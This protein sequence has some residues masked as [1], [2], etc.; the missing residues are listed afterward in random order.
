MHNFFKRIDSSKL[1]RAKAKQETLQKEAEEQNSGPKRPHAQSV[2]DLLDDD[3]LEKYCSDVNSSELSEVCVEGETNEPEPKNSQKTNPD[4]SYNDDNSGCNNEFFS[5]PDSLSSK[6]EGDEFKELN[7][8]SSELTK[9][10]DKTDAVYFIAL[11][12]GV[13]EPAYC[14]YKVTK[15][16]CSIVMVSQNDSLFEFFKFIDSIFVEIIEKGYLEVQIKANDEILSLLQDVNRLPYKVKS[17]YM[18]A[19]HCIRFIESDTEQIIKDAVK[20]FI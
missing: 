17:D 12:Y 15:N 20:S 3:F 4:S 13:C 11:V 14:A 9:L 16:S 2:T 1:N 10:D 19:K 5:N 8:E 18:L 6:Q 7:Y